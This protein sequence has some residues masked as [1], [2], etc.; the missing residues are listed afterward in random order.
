[1]PPLHEA[2]VEVHKEY[3]KASWPTKDMANMYKKATAAVDMLNAQCT[4]SQAENQWFSEQFRQTEE[5]LKKTREEMLQQVATHRP[6]ESD[7]EL[8]QKLQQAEDAL[9][10]T[11]ARAVLLEN[12]TKALED[13][14]QPTQREFGNQL[15]EKEDM[16]IRLRR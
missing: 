11:E 16:I 4:A 7:Q 3:A 12:Q 8:Q 15:T 14:Q 5:Q 1:M 2:L 9:K 10:Q 6:L 13:Q